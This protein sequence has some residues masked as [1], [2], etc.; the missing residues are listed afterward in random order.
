MEAKE[1]FPSDTRGIFDV[2]SFIKDHVLPLDP[3]EVLLILGDLRSRGEER[4][5]EDNEKRTS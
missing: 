5:A 2:L 3:L 4:Q 1:C